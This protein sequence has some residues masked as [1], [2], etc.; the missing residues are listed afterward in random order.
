MVVTSWILGT[1][2]VLMR[3]H[4]FVWNNTT[5][6]LHSPC[7]RDRQVPLHRTLTVGLDGW[8]LIMT[9]II[10]F[11]SPDFRSPCATGWEF[12]RPEIKLRMTTVRRPSLGSC[13]CH[14]RKRMEKTREQTHIFERDLG[15][16]LCSS[17]RISWM[18]W[19]HDKNEELKRERCVWSWWEKITR[20]HS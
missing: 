18:L 19:R 1:V 7:Y 12:V 3:N 20:S 11:F 16:M 2:E 8:R 17:G 9:F 4:G 15:R 14:T 10:F 13:T 5:K 6:S